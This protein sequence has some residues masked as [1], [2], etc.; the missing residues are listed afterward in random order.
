M[1]PSENLS[2]DEAQV[3]ERNKNEPEGLRMTPTE[4]QDPIG[5]L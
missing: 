2:Q 5:R 1:L 4:S 3:D